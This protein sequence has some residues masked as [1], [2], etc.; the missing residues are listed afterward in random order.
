LIKPRSR[1]GP[2]VL[3]VGDADLPQVNPRLAGL[4]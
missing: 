2:A 3:D 4:D 1:L